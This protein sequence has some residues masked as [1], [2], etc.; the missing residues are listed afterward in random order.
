MNRKELIFRNICNQK[1]ALITP[2]YS[3]DYPV[4]KVDV[5]KPIGCFFPYASP[6]G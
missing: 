1:Y 3:T 5:I 6:T 2:L 4:L